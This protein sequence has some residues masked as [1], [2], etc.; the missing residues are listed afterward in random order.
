[1]I[2]LIKNVRA[3][4]KGAWRDT[5]ILIAGT[6]VAVVCDAVEE[7][8]PSLKITDGHGM[9]AIPGYIDRHVHVIGGGGE[10]GFSNEVA[11]LQIETPIRCGVTTVCGLL[12]T[13]GT[14][15]SVESLAAKTMGLEE[16]GITAF[17]LTGS[18]DY[19]SPT[20]TGSVKRDIMFLPNCIGTKI[21]IADHRGSCLQD[22]E[23][24]RL[25]A[26]TWQAGILKGRS[27][28]VHLHVGRGKEGLSPVFRVL[29]K[30]EL[31][32][33]VFHPT[34]MG[35]QMD[36]AV[37]FAQMGGWTDFTV[38]DTPEQSVKQFLYALEYCREEY[39]TVSTDSN[40][41]VPVWNEQKEMI[42][43]G[44]GRMSTMHEMVRCLVREE[45]MPLERAIRPCTINA[46]NAL[47]LP[48]KGRLEA[49]A[50]ADIV[51]LDDDLNVQG[52]FA[53]GRELLREG[54]LTFTPKFSK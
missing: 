40:G 26:D 32:I 4:R 17:F 47:S 53:A 19:P 39:I 13:D 8:I 10:G 25:A 38:C 14:S 34:H 28:F 15:R 31:P 7:H 41:S 23:L 46:A 27:A 11:P 48:E 35:N 33:S 2:Q 6:K 9:Y 5:Q 20:I 45:G 43:I 49:E 24:A 1:M 42:G 18:Y 30:T 29:E 16:E 37:R 51:L 52:V 3:Y 12:G 36:D 21:A 54:E 50:D 22:A 44:T